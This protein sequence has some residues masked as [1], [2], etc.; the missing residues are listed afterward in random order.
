MSGITTFSLISL[1]LSILLLQ[2]VDI[3][4]IKDRGSPF[5]IKIEIALFAVTLYINKEDFSHRRKRRHTQKSRRA[6]IKLL[7]A[8]LKNLLCRSYVTLYA[9]A[10]PGTSP[11][12]LIASGILSPITI[13]Y[14]REHALSFEDGTGALGN[15]HVVEK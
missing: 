11:W 1:I 4:I 15:I 3:T 12:A 8:F 9:F 10:P 7:L 6:F 13:A 14:L 5:V 2:R